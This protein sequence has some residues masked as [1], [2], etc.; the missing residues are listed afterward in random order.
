MIVV[1][2]DLMVDIFLLPELRGAEQAGGLVLRG[3][4]SAANTAA[5]IARQRRPVTFFGC[6][7]ADSFGAALRQE[8]R[9]CGVDEQVRVVEDAETGCVAVE[10]TAG[11]ERMMRSSRGA[12]LSLCPADLAAAPHQ[13]HIVHLTGYALLG[14]YTFELLA[15]A[16]ALCRTSGARLSFDPSS[17]GVI[18]H[19]GPKRLLAALEENDVAILLPNAQ[20]ARLL[21]GCDDV[22]HA[23]RFLAGRIPTVLVKEGAGGS[24][25]QSDGAISSVPADLVEAVDTT[26]AGD[27]FNAGALVALLDGLG[28]SEAC[29]QG[30]EL[31][32]LAVTRYGG[33]PPPPA[34]LR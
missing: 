3:G 28:P 18:A 7:G 30:N 26:G 23:L 11:A 25:G 9:D 20:E 34:G 19:V 16:A 12:N 15:A 29:R 21:A 6:V 13:C 17:S 8:L 22:A 24:S 10:V 2:G 5:W 27:A 31:A 14:P 32:A 4:G 1:A 33:R